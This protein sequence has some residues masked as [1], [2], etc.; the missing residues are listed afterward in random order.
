MEWTAATVHCSRPLLCC[1]PKQQVSWACGHGQVLATILLG[2]YPAAFNYVEL[3]GRKPAH[4]F[5]DF[6]AAFALSAIPCAISLSN[7]G[8]HSDFM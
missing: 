7:T 6:T 3:A 8:L 1:V 2:G 4:T 5:L